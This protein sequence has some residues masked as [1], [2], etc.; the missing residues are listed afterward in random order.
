MGRTPHEA[1]L[2]WL[3]DSLALFQEAGWGWALWEL[4]R[5]FGVLDSGREDVAYEDFRGRK[6]DRRMF[7]ILR[8]RSAQSIDR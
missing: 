7:E 1:A 5:A 3:D 2:A 6:L 8:R 4:R